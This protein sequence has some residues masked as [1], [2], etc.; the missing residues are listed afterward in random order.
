VVCTGYQLILGIFPQVG[1]AQ[2]SSWLFWSFGFGFVF[3]SSS[4]VP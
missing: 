1:F 3:G 4:S 2:V